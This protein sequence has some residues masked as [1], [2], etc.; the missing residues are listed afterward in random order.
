[1]S[2]PALSY[3]ENAVFSCCIFS[4]DNDVLCCSIISYLRKPSSLSLTTY[5]SRSAP[6]QWRQTS[7]Y[8]VG[9]KQY[10]FI[11]WSLSSTILDVLSWCRLILLMTSYDFFFSPRRLGGLSEPQPTLPAAVIIINILMLIIIVIIANQS[12]LSWSW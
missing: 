10:I 1:M 2:S 6:T 12:W 5:C 7:C 4:Y 8:Q 9:E 3:Y 11:S